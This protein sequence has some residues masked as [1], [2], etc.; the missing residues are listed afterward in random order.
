MQQSITKLRKVIVTGANKGIGYEIAKLLYLEKD[1]YH[2]VITSRDINLGEKAIKNIRDNAPN[3]ENKVE[4]QQLEVNNEESINNF[5]NW[6]KES[7]GSFDVLVNNAGFGYNK[8]S[9]QDSVLTLN[10]NFFSLVDLTE[11]LLPFLSEDGKIIQISSGAGNLKNQGENVKKLL[12]NPS[13]ERKELFNIANDLL[14][15]TKNGQTN[16]LNWHEL[17]Y[18]NSKCLLNAY[19]RWVLPKV[20][21]EN[22]QCYSCTP[23]Y[24]RTDMTSPD[25][26]LSAEEGAMT[27]VYL[28]KLPFTKN[29]DLHTKF[30]RGQNT[31]SYE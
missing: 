30:F 29:P 21:Q 10:T 20:L 13:L 24:C 11:K 19:T 25:A 23:G 16:S 3:S 17:A 14:E 27:A 22:Q 4:L 28:V 15:S 18:Q 6:V 12:A 26:T 5:V 2:I 7:L 8:T 31:E 1:P 9:I